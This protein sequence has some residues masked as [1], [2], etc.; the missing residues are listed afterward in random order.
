[1]SYPRYGLTFNHFS[2]ANDA[3]CREAFNHDVSEWSVD[4]WLVAAFG[5]LGEAANYVKKLNRQQLP[6]DAE[7]TS[8]DVVVEIA[9]CVT[10]LDLL[11][12][13]LGYS[14][15][16]VLVEKFNA[17]NQ[18]VGYDQDLVNPQD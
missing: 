5:E 8:R 11:V 7:V 4:Q 12:T 14:L 17:V 2:E 16:D 18:R 6:G 9:D 10:Y 1:M 3:R 13:R 15:G